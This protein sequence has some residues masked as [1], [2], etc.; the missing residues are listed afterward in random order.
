MCTASWSIVDLI[1][2]SRTRTDQ[3]KLFEDRKRY[4][5]VSVIGI[6]N[7]LSADTVSS[8]CITSFKRLGQLLY[9]FIEI[10]IK[11][12]YTSKYIILFFSEIGSNF[13]VNMCL[14]YFAQPRLTLLLLHWAGQRLL[15]CLCPSDWRSVLRFTCPISVTGENP[16]TKAP[17]KS[18]SVKS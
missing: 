6:W 14:C 9:D 4:F 1:K 8:D 11:Y 3:F 15:Y 18:P 12:I 2:L 16:L 10:Y 13:P 5:S 7:S 17:D